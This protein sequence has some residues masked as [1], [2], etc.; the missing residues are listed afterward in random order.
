MPSGD[1][2]LHTLI[3]EGATTDGSWY[4]TTSA[5]EAI[6]VAYA[7]PGSDPF[8]AERGFVVWRRFTDDPPW[9]AMYG[10]AHPA[11]DGVVSTQALIVDLTGDGSPDALVNEITGGSGTCGTWR[12]VDLA[13]GYELWDRT[14]C[15]AQVVPSSDPVGIEITEAVFRQ[16]DA[17]CCPSATRTTVLTYTDDRRWTVVSKVLTPAGG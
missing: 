7:L 3:P 10:V 5:G 4:A 9:R 15:D 13:D 16:G 12:V 6:L 8:H 2:P 1:V 11:D 14:L 17:H